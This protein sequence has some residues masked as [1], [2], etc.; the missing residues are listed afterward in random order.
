MGTQSC[1]VF[2]ALKK[3]KKERKECSSHFVPRSPCGD[4]NRKCVRA[5]EAKHGA[6]ESG[7]L[8]EAEEAGAALAA[9]ARFAALAQVLEIVFSR[10]FS[11][12]LKLPWAVPAIT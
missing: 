12:V 6:E 8:G 2:T 10:Q 11:V 4:L 7:D 3:K 5:E 9:S 1:D